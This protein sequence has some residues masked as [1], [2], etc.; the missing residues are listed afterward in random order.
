MVL[1]FVDLEPSGR[2]GGDGHGWGDNGNAREM[3]D[4]IGEVMVMVE[5][6]ID[7]PNLT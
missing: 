2:R 4:I 7:K 6:M 5:E 3:M 1:L